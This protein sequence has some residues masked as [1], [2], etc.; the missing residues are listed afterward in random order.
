M[1]EYLSRLPNRKPAKALLAKLEGKDREEFQ[2]DLLEAL[3]DAHDADAL[4]QSIVG[5]LSEWVAHAHFEDSPVVAQRLEEV[6]GRVAS[7]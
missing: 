1:A 7:A 5:V 4:P 2:S 3:W 6:R